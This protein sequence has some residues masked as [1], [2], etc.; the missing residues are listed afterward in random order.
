MQFTI[1]DNTDR[2]YAVRPVLARQNQKAGDLLGQFGANDHIG[3]EDPYYVLI[4]D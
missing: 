2:S 4:R 3:E 1:N